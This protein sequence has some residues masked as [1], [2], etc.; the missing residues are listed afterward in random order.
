MRDT[1]RRWLDRGTLGRKSMGLSDWETMW[2]KLKEKIHVHLGKFS[3]RLIPMPD[4]KEEA[5]F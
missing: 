4:E 2:F 5:V 1:F 3:Y